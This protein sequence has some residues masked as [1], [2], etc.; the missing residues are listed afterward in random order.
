MR[1]YRA[2]RCT[3]AEATLV[4][5]TAA[6]GNISLALSTDILTTWATMFDVGARQPSAHDSPLKNSANGRPPAPINANKLLTGTLE[7]A[8]GVLRKKA[9]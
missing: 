6:P 8:H 5:S 4:S 7:R 9:A 1:I 3:G 2:E